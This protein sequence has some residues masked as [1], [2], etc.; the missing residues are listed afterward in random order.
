MVNYIFRYN[1]PMANNKLVIKYVM[2][3]VSKINYL[4]W[5]I[6]IFPVHQS[7]DIL[8]NQFCSNVI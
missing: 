8:H 6:E 7:I 3:I 5:M 2:I 4:V 1:T